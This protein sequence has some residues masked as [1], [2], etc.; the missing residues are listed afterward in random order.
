MMTNRENLMCAILEC[1]TLDL[2]VLDDVGYDWYDVLDRLEGQGVSIT[3]VGFNGLMRTV[4]EMAVEDLEA[5]VEE[6]VKELEEQDELEEDE[7]EALE[8]LRL[9]DPEDDVG[10]FFNFL[11]THA[12]FEKNGEV[13]RNYL[14]EAVE[15]FEK[16]TGLNLEGDWG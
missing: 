10:G 15:E 2:G 6:R 16:N 3:E 7:Q 9:L 8:Q 14:P 1:G 13:Y 5:A 11:D 4:V 12:Y